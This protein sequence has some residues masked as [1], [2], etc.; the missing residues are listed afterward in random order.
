LIEGNYNNLLEVC[1]FCE[2]WFALFF[3]SFTQHLDL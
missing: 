3:C 1:L 2:S